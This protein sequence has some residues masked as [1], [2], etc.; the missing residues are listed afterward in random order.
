MNLN[1]NILALVG[2]ANK[3]KKNGGKSA[4]PPTLSPSEK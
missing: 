2:K 4:F 3:A 1:T